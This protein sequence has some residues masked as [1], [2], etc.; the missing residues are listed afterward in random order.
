MA[1][2]QTAQKGCYLLTTVEHTNE[3]FRENA[4]DNSKRYYWAKNASS[5]PFSLGGLF[6]IRPA[7]YVNANFIPSD[8]VATLLVYSE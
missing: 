2:P 7:I 1:V 3:I 4:D 5:A 6:P 8:A